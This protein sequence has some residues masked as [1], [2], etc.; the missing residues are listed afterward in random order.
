MTDNGGNTSNATVEDRAFYVLG[1]TVLASENLLVVYAILDKSSVK[2]GEAVGIKM[3][4]R[5]FIGVEE[6]EVILKSKQQ[7]IPVKLEMVGGTPQYGTWEGSVVLDQSDQTFAL[8]MARIS[9]GEDTK[10]TRIYGQKVYVEYVKPLDLLE[11]ENAPAPKK[12]ELRQIV[13]NPITPLLIGLIGMGLAMLIVSSM[14]FMKS[15]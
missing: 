4:I 11:Q 13:R 12:T 2:P 9:N 3:D 5:D 1:D 15:E 14:T 7:E 10:E 6:V 8:V